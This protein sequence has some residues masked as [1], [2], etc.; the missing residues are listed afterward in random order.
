MGKLPGVF[1]A[2][3]GSSRSMFAEIASAP[4]HR[5]LR[6]VWRAVRQPL[7]RSCRHCFG[8]AAF[9]DAAPHAPD[10]PPIPRRMPELEDHRD[11]RP[12]RSGYF[13]AGQPVLP[14]DPLPFRA[15][16]NTPP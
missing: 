11:G 2:I 7:A 13:R 8:I 10:A 9:C 1:P 14:P 6:T 4:P 16:T 3:A 12:V 15:E 5:I